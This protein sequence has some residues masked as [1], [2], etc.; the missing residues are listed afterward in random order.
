MISHLTFFKAQLALSLLFKKK[1]LFQIS[2]ALNLLKG[3]KTYKYI[4]NGMESL[5]PMG[6]SFIIRRTS[7]HRDGGNLAS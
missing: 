2:A 6:D 5:H 4:K 3:C 7:V 1:T